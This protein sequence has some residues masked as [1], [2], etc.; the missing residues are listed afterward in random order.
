MLLVL[1]FEIALG[2][3]VEGG[4]QPY[5]G[6]NGRWAPSNLQQANSE[7]MSVGASLSSYV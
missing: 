7:A 5:R 2:G 1:I 6:L 3:L 4:A